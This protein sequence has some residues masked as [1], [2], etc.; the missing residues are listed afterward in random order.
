MQEITLDSLLVL[1]WT[2]FFSDAMLEISNPCPWRHTGSEGLFLYL[3][4][5]P[6]LLCTSIHTPQLQ[7]KKKL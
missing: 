1:Q 5:A 7:G 2:L 6:S 3:G 4:D